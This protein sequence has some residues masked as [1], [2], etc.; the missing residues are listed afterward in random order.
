MDLQGKSQSAGESVTAETAR[1]LRLHPEDVIDEISPRDHMYNSDPPSYVVLGQSGLN[2]VRLAM[3]AAG[4]KSADSI[5]DLPSGHGRVI[6]YLKA[7]FPNATLTACDIDRDAVD[8]CAGAFGATPI[9]G[10]P[11]PA[12]LHLLEGNFD[13]IWCGSL[14]SHLDEPLWEGFLD[15]FESALPVGGVL[16]MTTQGREIAARLRDPEVRDHYMQSEERRQQI[17]RGFE[18]TGFG[19]ADYDFPDDFRNKLSLPV[20]FGIAVAQPSHVCS[21]LERR[22]GLRLIS[23]V[24]QAWGGQDVIAC[25]RTQPAPG[26]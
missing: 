14:L 3:L 23:Y 21:I 9:Y 10:Q 12:D 6:R 19:Y 16:V 26:A 18:E 2:M 24:E 13:L 1:L 17:L 7:E 25:V 5:L 15:V 22:P 4:K 8:F 11:D 20:N